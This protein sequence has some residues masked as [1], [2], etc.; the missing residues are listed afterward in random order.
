MMKN[1][2]LQNHESFKVKLSYIAL[3]TQGLSK[4]VQLV[5]LVIFDLFTA[6]LNFRPYAFV[7][8]K[9]EKSVSQNVLNTNG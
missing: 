7:W 9:I 4:F 1:L 5:I 6:R 8:G 2:L 3:G